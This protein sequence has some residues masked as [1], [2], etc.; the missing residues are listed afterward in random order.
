MNSPS[1]PNP[2]MMMEDEQQSI[3]VTDFTNESA[4]QF[5][6]ALFRISEKDPNRPIIVY[7]NSPGGEI[8][9]LGTMMSAM[10]S[11]PNKI[12]TVA[13]GHAMSA[14]CM[15]LAH[16]SIRFASPHAVIMAHKV[17]AGAFGN[18][19]DIVNESEQI[20]KINEYYMG[21]F[22]KDTKKSPAEVEK[23]LGGT[24]REVYLNAQQ[25]VD[26]GIVDSIGIPRVDLAPSPPV[27][28]IGVLAAAA[29]V[30]K[31]TKPKV[32]KKAKK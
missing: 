29:P 11:I 13:M 14:G 3:W 20:V 17:S 16:G 1:M 21:L 5:C 19:D 9:A 22:A 18:V 4:T 12:I 25:A 6:N 15:L 23:L 31:P 8:F 7:I 10:D 2:E 30:L 32:K 28:Q 26:F 24:R 27:Y